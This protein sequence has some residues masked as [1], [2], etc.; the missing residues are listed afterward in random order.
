MSLE[1]LG[2]SSSGFINDVHEMFIR[3]SPR[4]PNF[5][6]SKMAPAASCKVQNDAKKKMTGSKVKHISPCHIISHVIVTLLS[7]LVH[8]LSRAATFG[9]GRTFGPHF[10]GP[11]FDQAWTDLS[12]WA[13]FGDIEVADQGPLTFVPASFQIHLQKLKKIMITFSRFSIASAHAF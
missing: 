12:V 4:L 10:G 11:C 2:T 6:A 9:P 8:I 1:H 5:F 7:H 3:F 13:F